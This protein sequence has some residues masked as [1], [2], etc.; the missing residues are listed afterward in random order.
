[1]FSHELGELIHV[2]VPR[3]IPRRPVE[4]RYGFE[5]RALLVAQALAVAALFS[6]PV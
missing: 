4:C 1:M 5:S 6:H 3:I 2:P